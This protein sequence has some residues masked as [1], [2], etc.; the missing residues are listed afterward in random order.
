[1]ERAPKLHGS[2]VREAY[3][4]GLA[5]QATRGYNPY[6][7][8]VVGASDSHD[9]ASGYSQT[10]YFGGHG[11]LDANPAQRLSGKKEAGMDLSSLSTA[12][13]GGVWAEQNT[14]ES[15]FA[16][17]QRKETF[18]TSGV[19]I[20][21]RFFGGWGLPPEM[22]AQKDWVKSAYQAGVPMGGDLPARKGRAPSFIV[23]A[24]K[25]PDDGNLDRIQIVK[26]WTQDGQIFEKIY[27][28]VWSGNRRPQTGTGKVPPVGSTVN[29]QNASYTNTIGAT[30]LKKVWTDPAFDPGLNAFYYARVIQIPTPR[31][32][33][34]DANKLGVAPPS[35]VSATV[36]ERAWTSPIW[37]APTTEDAR[38]DEKTGITVADL[39][40][41]GAVPLNDSQLKELIVG[42]TV[43]VRNQVTG[44]RIEIL[45]GR[46][47]RRLITSIDGKQPQPG[48]PFDVM[49]SGEL[50][51][52]AAYEIQGGRLITT[53]GVT[54]F[55]IRVYRQ[56]NKLL[57]ARSNEFGY[58]NYEVEGV[59]S[60]R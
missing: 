43:R 21:V 51:S 1:M 53:V 26:G 50:G 32:T 30:E 22:L 48:E 40:K 8:G 59:E 3:E 15:I 47:G 37:Y 31:W 25:D 17:M 11:L 36:Q 54:P 4:N 35:S 23:W 44:Q 41:K 58:A 12:G 45:Y 24:V 14:R 16:A 13:L 33:T 6:K 5:M 60:D 29:I 39:A 10:N 18:G 56:G 20:R 46:D 38:K 7:M 9:T 55:E 34:Y 2:Y 57:A 42:K 52:P 49:A 28:V 19:R 27:D